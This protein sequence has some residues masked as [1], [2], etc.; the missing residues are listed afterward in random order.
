VRPRIRQL[1][2]RRAGNDCK[3]LPIRDAGLRFSGTSVRIAVCK[4]HLL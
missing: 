3:R 2:N 1:L 4:N